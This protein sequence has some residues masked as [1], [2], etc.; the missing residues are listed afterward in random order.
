MLEQAL[1]DAV[2]LK[3]AALKNAEMA[4]IEKYATEVRGT[5]N[6]L[7]EQELEPEE[8]I[9]DIGS[10]VED[11]MD[12]AATEDEQACP[13]PEEKEVKTFTFTIDD[14]REIEQALGTEL[15]GLPPGEGLE[16]PE[17]LAMQFGAEEGMP[18]EEE[19]EE[20]E[21]PLGLQEDI[22]VDE[23]ILFEY[24]E[25]EESEDLI[26]DLD[27]EKLAEELIV[28]LSGDELTG[29]AGRPGSDIQY[30]KQ[31]RLAKLAATEAQEE[32]K[33]LESA[34][35]KLAESNNELTDENKRIKHTLVTLK[36]KLEEVNLSN[37][38]LLYM[39]RTLNSTSL[40]ERQKKKIVES[41]QKTDSVKEAKVV[42]ETLQSAVGNSRK[43][44]PKSLREAIRRPSLTMPSRRKVD[45]E[46]ESVAKER[47]KKLAGIK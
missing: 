5:M 39:N 29:W 15:D 24:P 38:K 6:S 45:S 32:K 26:E 31:I 16:S 8:P 27:I 13:C 43:D 28:D 47:F 12:F 44:T 3:E 30:A 17:E 9:S 4:I 10:G 33:E 11:Q 42:F 2:T 41:I 23:E 20:E 25:E 7:L 21:L 1:V 36:E 19:E 40:N 35:E 37:A 22:E 14:F 34:I 46:H 18:G